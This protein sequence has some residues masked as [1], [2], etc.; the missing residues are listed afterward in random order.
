MQVRPP[1]LHT[2]LNKGLA[3]SYL[4]SGDEPLQMGEAADEI[5]AAARADGFGSRDV[6]EVDRSFNW[7]ELT[8][9]ASNLS[10]FSERRIIDLRI[11]SGKP[12][13]QGGKALQEYLQRPPEDTMLLVTMPK[14]EPSQTTSKWF[15]ALDSA[16]VVVRVWPIKGEQLPS[17]IE[18]RMRRDGLQPE[19]GVAAML[20]E[21]IEGNLLAATQEI[22]K[23][24]LLHGP[25]AISTQQLIDA[26][27][28]SSRFNVFD[29]ADSALAGDSGRCIRIINGLEAEGTAAPLVL[30][31]LSRDLRMLA[32]LAH[33][34]KKGRSPQQAV[35]ARRDIWQQRKQLVT[36]ALQRR[37]DWRQLLLLCGQADRAIKGRS[38]HNPWLLFKDI[39]TGMCGVNPLPQ[40]KV[41][42]YG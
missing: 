28:D 17:W 19:P 1:N 6:I 25:T 12:G 34:V 5:R 27:A 18:Q 10:L 26:V 14:L 13:T 15:K 2:H 3:S 23:L 38:R 8:A 33:Q 31:A 36:S 30:W 40:L 20:A 39:A 7:D 42:N 21:R 41:S 4:L 32:E 9:E 35:G 22:E 24:L 11:P 37:A 16:G 29:L